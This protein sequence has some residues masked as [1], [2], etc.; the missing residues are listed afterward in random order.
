MERTLVHDR[1]KVKE[2]LSNLSVFIFILL[3]LAI[4]LLKTALVG[5][6]IKE[7]FKNTV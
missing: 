3:D 1:K 4:T 6:N 5:H 7:K 2:K